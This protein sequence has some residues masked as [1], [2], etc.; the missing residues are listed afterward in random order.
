MLGQSVC[1][2]V[3]VKG[4][5][6]STGDPDARTNDTYCLGRGATNALI[7]G[8]IFFVCWLV[9]S[10]LVSSVTHRS[11]SDSSWSAFAIL[12]MP[13]FLL[14]LGTWLYGLNAGGRVLL[15]CGPHPTRVGFLFQVGNVRGATSS[16]T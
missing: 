15:D 8:F 14:F 6:S 7:C 11:L 4:E 10:V 12:W 1:Y 9:V 5:F 3:T 16:F 13:I 2:S